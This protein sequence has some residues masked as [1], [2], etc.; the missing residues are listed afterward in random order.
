MK[1]PWTAPLPLVTV[2]K[3]ADPKLITLIY[4]YYSNP[5]FFRLQCAWW[6]T[7]PA[8]LREHLSVIVVDDGSP[9]PATLPAVQPFPMR[10]FRIE[11]DV[12]WNW[13]AAR[14]IGFHHAPEGWCI[15]TDMDHVIP[16]ST[17]T[18]LVYG[19]HDPSVIYALSRI[20]HSGEVLGSHPNS[21]VMTRRMFWKIGGYDEALSGMYGSDGDF[22]RRCAAKA[23]LKLLSDR[24]VRHEYHLDSSTTAYK[25]KQPEDNVSRLVSARGKGWKP[26]TL[27]FPY[28]E[29]PEYSRNPMEVTSES[30]M[31]VC[32]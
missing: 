32:P 12:R 30:R 25:R 17:A 3:G 2:P 13:L 20:E 26:R 14:N 11:V 10:L 15:V 6:S 29:A 4:P 22:R 19:R 8:W 18:S 5:D 21:F 24:L 9:I 16:E 7:Y 31:N 28:H 1:Q 27:S 23:Q